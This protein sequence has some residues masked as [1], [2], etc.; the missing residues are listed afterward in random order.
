MPLPHKY[1]QGPR[2]GSSIL[3]TTK[4]PKDQ[5]S[6]AKTTN[7]IANFSFINWDILR[8]LMPNYIYYNE[9]Y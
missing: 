8:Y 3:R 2:P 1:C 5:R 9:N 6:P 7:G 4:G